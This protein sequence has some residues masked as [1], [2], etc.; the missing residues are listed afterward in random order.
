LLRDST[1]SVTTVTD[2]TEWKE[3][4][5]RQDSGAGRVQ[6]LPVLLAVLVQVTL[7]VLQYR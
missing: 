1:L 7:I 3:L 2:K 6:E 5:E 4:C